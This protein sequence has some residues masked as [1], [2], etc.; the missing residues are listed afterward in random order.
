MN[1]LHKIAP[2]IPLWVKQI[3]CAWEDLNGKRHSIVYR[4]SD[5]K[6]SMIPK[7]KIGNPNPLFESK[8]TWMDRGW[9]PFMQKADIRKFDITKMKVV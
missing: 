4:T 6:L 1:N 2:N 7:Y 9:E 3:F 5:G 8:K